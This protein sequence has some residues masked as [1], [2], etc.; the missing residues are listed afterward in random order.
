MPLRRLAA[1]LFFSPKRPSDPT[2]GVEGNLA[3]LNLG[4]RLKLERVFSLLAADL[5]VT[6][7]F[8]QVRL[9]KYGLLSES[10]AV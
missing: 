9:N 1:N 5:G 2:C 4:V 7:R 6:R 8:V 10:V 3:F